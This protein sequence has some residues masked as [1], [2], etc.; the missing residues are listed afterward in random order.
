MN[1]LI[2]VFFLIFFAACSQKE[3]SE[4]TPPHI[5]N[6]TVMAEII[7]EIHLLDAVATLQTA[8]PVNFGRV[9]P[10]SIVKSILLKHHITKAQL[11]TSMK[12]YS[13]NPQKFSLIYEKAINNLKKYKE[14]YESKNS[15]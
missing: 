8:E 14:Q 15:K 5:I 10:D 6:D 1:K 4:S 3:E 7:S 13:F 12:Y 2:I 9:K 11:D